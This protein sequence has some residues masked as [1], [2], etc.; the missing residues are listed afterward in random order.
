MSDIS[1]RLRVTGVHNAHISPVSISAR[2]GL[3]VALPQMILWAFKKGASLAKSLLQSRQ[4]QSRSRFNL[5]FLRTGAMDRY[6]R[7]LR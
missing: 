6:D 4:A 5:H 3:L 7:N 2:Y 1:K